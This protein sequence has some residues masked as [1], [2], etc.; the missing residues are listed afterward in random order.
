MIRKTDLIAHYKMGEDAANTTVAD[1]KGNHNG[2]AQ[3]NTNVIQRAGNYTFDTARATLM[4]DDCKAT[5]YTVMKPVFDT[6]GIV[7]CCAIVTDKVGTTDRMTW[8]QIAELQAAGWEILYHGKD[9]TA[10]TTLS[11][12]EI[13]TDIT[14]AMSAFATNS[15]T[16]Q[17][18]A[19]PY[20]LTDNDVKS[21]VRRYFNC[22]G[23]GEGLNSQTQ[24]PYHLLRY[25]ADDHTTLSTYQGYV[26]TAESANKWVIFY[27]HETNSNDAA[28][29]GSLIDYIQ[30]KGIPIITFQQSLDMSLGGYGSCFDFN[31]TSDFITISD[32]DDF[33]PGDGATGSP[34]SISAWVFIDSTDAFPIASKGVYNT[35]GEWRLYVDFAD[36]YFQLYDESID[37][38][39]IGRKNAVNLS[40]GTWYHLVGTYDGGTSSSGIK[41]YQ[42]GVQC[43]T[44]NVQNN[45]SSFESAENDLGGDVWPG[46]YSTAYANGLMKNMMFFNREINQ[47][48]V[49]RLYNNGQGTETLPGLTSPMNLLMYRR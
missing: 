18:M 26:D 41:L 30:G 37:D 2:T 20:N 48:D 23:N 46:R 8:A 1:D 15:I 14:G 17:N 29:I 6:K 42:D 27:L 24:A 21:V 28:A 7:G 9:H 4:F 32:H 40:T 5:D 22:A 16:V 44:A 31:G 13:V 19:Y 3:Q 35:N 38:G 25:E 34:F 45:A 39:R 47:A 36:L 10:L 33:S 43:D 11:K 12:A 49:T